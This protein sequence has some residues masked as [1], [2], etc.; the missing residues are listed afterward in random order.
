MFYQYNKHFD[1]VDQLVT[2]NI[3]AETLN[4]HHTYIVF[5]TGRFRVT[6]N[7]RDDK[8]CVP[9]QHQQSR[10]RSGGCFKSIEISWEERGRRKM[11]EVE[12]REQREEKNERS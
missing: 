2:G 5:L 1:P 8:S 3:Y 4:N 10:D 6:N 7:R 12:R 11:R 9:Y